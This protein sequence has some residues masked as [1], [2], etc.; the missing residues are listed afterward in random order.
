MPSLVDGFIYKNTYMYER[1][2][3]RGL[4]EEEYKEKGYEATKER[5]LDF[6]NKRR[7]SAATDEAS[8]LRILE[9]INNSQPC[10]T[11]EN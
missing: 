5:I 6:Y 3:T 8:E 9:D 2:A 10:Q 7:E 1:S 4:I 11:A